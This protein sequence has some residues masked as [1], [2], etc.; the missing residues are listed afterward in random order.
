MSMRNALPSL[1]RLKAAAGV[2]LVS[3]TGARLTRER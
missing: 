1:D 3:W 2:R